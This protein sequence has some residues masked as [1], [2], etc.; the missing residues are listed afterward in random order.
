MKIMKRLGNIIAYLMVVSLLAVGG[1]ASAG[2]AGIVE[3]L[4]VQSGVGAVPVS[5]NAKMA[6][7]VSVKDFGAAGDGMKDDT[8]AIQ[9]AVTAHMNVYFPPGNYLCN[10]IINLREGSNLFGAG[11]KATRIIRNGMNVGGQGVLYANSASASVQLDGIVVRDMT[12]DGQVATLGFSEHRHLI[13]LNG[14][15]NARIERVRFVG[16][17]GDGLYIGTGLSGEERHNKD[18]TVRD[19]VFDGVNKENRNGISVIDVDG[20]VI[21]GNSFE[22]ITKATMPGAID[23]EPNG[24]SAEII[25]NITVADNIF[26]NIG[27]N[28]GTV[29]VAI[30]AATAPASGIIIRGNKFYSVGIVLTVSMNRAPTSSTPDSAVTFTGNYASTINKPFQIFGVRGVSIT[31]NV[32]VSTLGTALIGYDTPSTNTRDIILSKNRFME[33]ATASVGVAVQVAGVDHLTMDANHFENCGMGAAGSNVV[34]FSGAGNPTSSFVRML[35]NT[36]TNSAGKALVAVAKDP[37]HTF[38]TATNHEWGNDWA[39]LTAAFDSGSSYVP[40]I[41]GSTGTEGVGTYTTQSG[42]YVLNGKLCTVYAS[43]AWTAHTGAGQLRMSLPFVAKNRSAINFP[44]VATVSNITFTGAYISPYAASGQNYALFVQNVTGA[45]STNV[46]M[47]TAGS[48][49]VSVTYEI[50]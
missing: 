38:T 5:Q 15:R 48:M 39:G 16:F 24:T 35:N 44:G 34:N 23:F 13:S 10:G 30:P 18:I 49:T 43:L 45:A 40:V 32:F 20:I 14:V 8:A 2:Q 21:A 27:G 25:K 50:Q 47:D 12:L 3:K 28:V 22:N 41:T 46:A 4:F 11:I 26:R 31:E 33:C 9:A 29:A 19:S 7:F 17:R 42:Y 6:Q 37:N 36:V 1:S